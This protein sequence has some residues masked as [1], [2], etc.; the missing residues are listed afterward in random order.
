MGNIVVSLDSTNKISTITQNKLNFTQAQLDSYK[1]YLNTYG[2]IK[3]TINY[4]LLFKYIENYI[5]TNVNA[6]TFTM[7]I[8]DKNRIINKINEIIFMAIQ[9]LSISGYIVFNNI[10]SDS[11][12]PLLSPTITSPPLIQSMPS[13]ISNIDIIIPKVLFTSSKSDFINFLVNNFN[14]NRPERQSFP[15][16]EMQL[17]IILINKILDSLNQTTDIE[18]KITNII[19]ILIKSFITFIIAT[20]PIPTGRGQDSKGTMIFM[21]TNIAID[22]LQS[23]PADSCMFTQTKLDFMQVGSNICNNPIIPTTPVV[24]PTLGPQPICPTLKPTICPTLKP[25]IC[26]TL[27]TPTSPT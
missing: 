6:L 19:G 11:F 12:N 14:N 23:I 2:V 3:V 8:I 25:T 13:N 27:A 1:N 21:Y 4:N 9:M 26:P 24:C 15:E 7:N 18:I 16:K 5:N 17:F 22:V 10:N 20:E